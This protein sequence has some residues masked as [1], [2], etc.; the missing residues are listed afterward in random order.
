[1]EEDRRFAAPGTMKRQIQIGVWAAGF[2]AVLAVVYRFPPAEHSFYPRCPFFAL[3]HLLCPGCGGTRALHEL[4]HLNLAGALHYNALLTVLAPFAMA[5]LVWCF[6]Q[7][8]RYDHFP[9]VRWPRSIAF[10]LAF[11]FLL[12][13]VI[14]NTSTAFAI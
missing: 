5:W 13:A 6:Y 1:M 14:R 2:C 8:F 9:R 7:V 10:G 11:V 12:F 4:L 3:T